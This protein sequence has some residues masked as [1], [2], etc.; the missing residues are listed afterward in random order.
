M[1]DMSSGH[2]GGLADLPGTFT[3]RRQIDPEWFEAPEM[4]RI[5]AARDIGALYRAL[6]GFGI[7]QRRI[8]SLTGQSQS[9]VSE[10]LK[11]RRV[12]DVTVLERIA[13]GLG[14]PRDYLRLAGTIND[15]GTYS[16]TGSNPDSEVDEDMYRRALIA[17]T[18]LA[19]LGQVVKGLGELAEL[20][21]PGIGGEPLPTRLSMSHVHAVEAV[22]RQLR[23]VA[24]QY[25]GQAEVFA[26]AARHYTRWLG[27]P[28]ADVVKARLG[29]ALAELHTEAGWCYYDSGG[30]GAG[31]FIRSLK[32]AD[33]A[34]DAYGIANAAW[35]AGATLMRSGHPDDALKAFQLGR[36]TLD[37]FQPGKARPATLR[38][39]DPRVSTLTARLNRNSATAYA[40]MGNPDDAKRHLD[41]AHDGWTPRDAFDHGGMDLAT[42]GVWL[43]L[44]R[45]DTAQ[46]FA[47]SSVNA[48]GEVFTRERTS[49]ELLLAE[50]HVRSGE[51]RGLVLARQAIDGVNTLQSVALRRER[52]QPLA[53]ALEAYPGSDARELARSARRVMAGWPR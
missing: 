30:N 51:P 34:G 9:E 13:D 12:R 5:L 46:H 36:F 39:D 42:A 22:T 40:L 14:I 15:D 47:L 20:A 38:A 35:H 41:K 45:L 32:L 53:A 24:R 27:I 25:G 19:A 17:A 49:A 23:N 29:C 1:I 7:S 50:V 43:D 21:L 3:G 31:F 37:G 28:A 11:G 8:A 26:A 52:L 18:S 48:Y 33:D 2:G 4:R 16:G 6:T 10:I 44:R